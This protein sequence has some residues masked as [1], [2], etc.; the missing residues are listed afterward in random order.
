MLSSEF[1]QILN[2]K[3]EEGL[4]QECYNQ[5]MEGKPIKIFPMFT[6]IFPCKWKNTA[7]VKRIRV[8]FSRKAKAPYG[9][10]LVL[11]GATPC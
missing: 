10:D 2:I 11:L 7:F 8:L 6:L 4:S 1:L 3:K 9:M 5:M